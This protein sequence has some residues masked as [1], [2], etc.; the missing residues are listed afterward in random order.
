MNRENFE[1]LL[2]FAERLPEKEAND[3][4]MASIMSTDDGSNPRGH[5]Q[6]IIVM[7]ELAELAQEI[8]K[9]IRGKG[10]HL[11]LIEE[12]AD[13]LIG[14]RYIQLIENISNKTLGRAVAVKLQ[15]LKEAMGKRR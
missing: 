1:K 4:L 6:M 8:S 2:R 11:G 10:D 13:V 12:C 14:I 7:E 15:R 9:T 3:I 5:L